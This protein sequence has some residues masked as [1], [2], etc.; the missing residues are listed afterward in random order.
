MKGFGLRRVD[1]SQSNAAFVG[2]VVVMVVMNWLSKVTIKPGLYP[3][4]EIM[5]KPFEHDCQ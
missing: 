4:L 5:F 3:L 2:G 1:K